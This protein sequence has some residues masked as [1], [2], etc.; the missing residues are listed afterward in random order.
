MHDRIDRSDDP[1]TAPLT[2]LYSFPFAIGSPGIGMTA[3][4]QVTELVAAGHSVHLVTASMARDIP[5]LASLRKTLVVAGRR[6]PHRL[7][8]QHRAFAYT[9]AVASRM[10]ARHRPDVVHT[11]PLGA[12]R[13]LR[14]AAALG[15]P[16]LREV[17]NTHTGHAYAVVAEEYARL[18]LPVPPGSSH[19]YN[20]DRLREEE[21][22][23][24]LAEGLLVPSDTVAQSFLDRDFPEERLLRHRY[25]YNPDDLGA[26]PQRKAAA[27]FTAVFVGRCEPRKG[28]H[29]ALRAWRASNASRTGRF[30]IY[31]N[32]IPGYREH[33]EPLL[34]SP[35]VEVRGFT[36]KVEDAFAEADVLLLPTVEEGSALVTYEAQAL[37]CVPLVSTESGAYIV[38]GEHGLTHSPG[39]VGAL[40]EHLDRLDSDRALL[41]R[42]RAR[43]LEH[44]PD[45]T[46][47]AANESLVGNYR[48]AIART[49][50]A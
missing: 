27:P 46:W 2:V 22:E 29:H 16:G 20:E 18:G 4:N 48:T 39:D 24:S 7:L 35:G 41:A 8:G 11:W 3:W 10:V 44:A 23:W 42:M 33:L 1:R 12:K 30:L 28:L 50:A 14:A 21:A 49:A 32:F 19:E 31:G 40:T 45:L 36:S 6:V 5:G 9:D 43:D 37:G 34:D 26:A 38:D 25:G 17:P 15:I 47:A 13:T